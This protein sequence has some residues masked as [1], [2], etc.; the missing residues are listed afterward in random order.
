GGARTR[1]A[2]WFR[3]PAGADPRDSPPEPRAGPHNAT[4]PGRTRASPRC[5][6]SRRRRG[7]EVRWSRP[8][9]RA[10]PAAPRSGAGGTAARGTT[11]GMRP[12]DSAGVGDRSWIEWN[13]QTVI[14]EAD[15][16][17]QFRVIAIVVVVVGEVR[18]ERAARA[19]AARGGE[20]LVEAHVGGMRLPA[21]RVEHGDLDVADLLEDFLADGRA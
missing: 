2:T 3:S 15:A 12:R 16:G 9:P 17:R 6:G 7:R 20:R 1:R 18:E 4:P 13:L 19:D 11:A 5:T 8:A 14:G 21:E 10:R